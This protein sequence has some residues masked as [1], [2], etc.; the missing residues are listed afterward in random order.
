MGASTHTYSTLPSAPSRGTFTPQSRSRVTARGCNPASI[1]DLHWPYTLAFQSPLCC[2]K[3]HSRNQG[4]SWSSGR[5]QC[6]VSR[7]TG[8]L[9]LSADLG[10]IRSVALS[11]VPQASHWSP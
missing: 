7:N 1:H 9:P 10:L 6:L 8:G 3:I 2:S 11:E 5:N 4:S